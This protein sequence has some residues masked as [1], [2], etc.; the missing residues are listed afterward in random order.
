[1]IHII[2]G[3]NRP[4]SR[5]LTLAKQV[6]AFHEKQFE[7]VRLVNLEELDMSSLNGEQYSK[8]KPEH[9]ESLVEEL[10]ASQGFVIVCPEYNGSMPGILKYF[11]DHWRFPDT[12][13][14][15]PVCFI[16]LGGRYG[17]LRPVEHLQQVF[18]YRNA[19]IFP[20][21]VFVAN[22]WNHFDENG[23]TDETL[24]GLLKKQAEG[25]KSFVT[26][27]NNSGLDANT[28]LSNNLN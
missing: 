11:I 1:M 7:D 14:Y 2:S 23:V 4:N 12:F 5:S 24:V 13:E 3:T 28:F 9:I 26:A 10:T 8:N 20:E 22:V 19:F 18:G 25:F 21:R 27:I 6:M 16:G 15:R 17:G